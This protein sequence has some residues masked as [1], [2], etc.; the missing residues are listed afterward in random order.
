M[1]VDIKYYL[2]IQNICSVDVTK[3]KPC[4]L[5]KEVTYTIQ[6]YRSRSIFSDGRWRKTQKGLSSVDFK[7]KKDGTVPK[8]ITLEGFENTITEKKWKLF[9]FYEMLFNDHGIKYEIDRVENTLTATGDI[10]DFL[11]IAGVFEPKTHHSFLYPI[12]LK[13]VGIY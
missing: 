13:L 1:I 9:D 10:Q 8:R 6:Q 7:L 12:K 3:V 2:L 5:E 11:I 4:Q